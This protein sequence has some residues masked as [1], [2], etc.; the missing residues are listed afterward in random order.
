MSAFLVCVIRSL[1]IG[2]WTK[3]KD[4]FKVPNLKNPFSRY[5]SA[6]NYYKSFSKNIFS[7]DID[8]FWSVVH[9]V[10]ERRC[11]EPT[12]IVI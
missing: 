3:L 5:T 8:N 4:S 6:D 12:Y 7:H 1:D 11:H 9:K 10:V 2:T